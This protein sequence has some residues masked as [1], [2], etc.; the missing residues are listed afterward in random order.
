MSSIGTKNIDLIYYIMMY[1]HQLLNEAN[2]VRNDRG[3]NFPQSHKNTMNDIMFKQR[4]Y[5]Q[6]V[7]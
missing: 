3:F 4:T 2:Q 1:I 7:R 6:K 5:K